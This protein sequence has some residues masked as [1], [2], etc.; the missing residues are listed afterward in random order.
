LKYAAGGLIDVEFVAQLLQLIHAADHPDILH[1]STARV[2]EK[3]ARM[4]LLAAEDAD[5]LRGAARLYHDL[6]Q[7]LRLCLPGK[8]E[9][10][11]AGPG[12]QALLAR[13]G[14]VP[15]L[16]TLEASLAEMQ[17][18]VRKSFLRI[19]CAER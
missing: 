4:R 8:F 13:A 5:A 6:S 10:D 11:K 17:A 12:L 18:R 3:A 1:M 7:I 9:P 2:L 15:D 19:V 14:D 16:P